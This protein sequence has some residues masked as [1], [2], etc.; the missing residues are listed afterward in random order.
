[1]LSRLRKPSVLL[2]AGALILV[3]G[4]GS[5]TAAGLIGSEDVENN[6]LR[7]I[8]IRD[9]TLTG[10]DVKDGSLQAKELTDKAVDS[11][12]TKYVGPNWS[13]VDRNVIG[14]GDSYLRSGPGTVPSGVGSL[15]LRT[16]SPDDKAAFGNQVDFRD[17]LVKDLTAVKFSV[18]TTAENRA[19]APNNMPSIAF[20]IDPNREDKPTTTYS[21]LVYAPDNTEASQWTTLDAVT[22]TTP[23][24]GLTGSA[25]NGT[26]CSINGARC[27]F[28]EVQDYLDDGGDEAVIT[29]SVQITKGRDYAFS[30]AVDDLIINSTTYNFE[31]FGVFE[32]PAS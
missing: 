11:L 13:I 2:S 1:M 26:E 24:W 32:T 12:R 30:G 10:A 8:D 5:A 29:F 16:G 19:K 15:G 20:E 25:F 6:S 4:V 21:T 23:H 22:D 17:D 28:Q 27:T 18:Y 7:S 3:A 9:E 31:P 14:N